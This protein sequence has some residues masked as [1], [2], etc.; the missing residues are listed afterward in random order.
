MTKCCGPGWRSFSG[1][2]TSFKPLAAHHKP[3]FSPLPNE[4]SHS[5]S[6]C[7]TRPPI[8]II[9]AAGSELEQL[10]VPNRKSYIRVWHVNWWT[11]FPSIS[12]GGSFRRFLPHESYP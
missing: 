3:Y 10:A 6:A 8:R 2:R 11:T 12:G 4:F 9:D 5:L 7:S 1:V